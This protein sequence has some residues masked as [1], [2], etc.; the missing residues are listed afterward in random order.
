MTMSLYYYTARNAEGQAV[1]GSLEAAGGD[2]ALASLRTRALFVT[3]LS[4]ARSANGRLTAG[5]QMG[6]IRQGSLVAFF[7]SF[8]TLISAGVPM[9]RALAVGVEQA[10]DARFREALSAVRADVDAG[11]PLSLAMSKR[12]K[13]F[14]P[15]FVAM[16]HAG[17][18]GGVLDEVLERLAQFVERERVIRKRLAS[19]LTYPAIVAVSAAVLITFLL[20]SIVPMFASLYAQLHVELPPATAALLQV[21]R[22]ARAPHVWMLLG[23]IGAPA[24]L[25]AGHALRS[26]PGR[27]LIDKAKLRIPIVGPILRKTAV[28]RLTRMLGSLLKS[29]VNLVTAIDVASDVVAN[30]AYIAS[31]DDV[32]RSL[33]E[34]EAFAQPLRQSRLYE[35]LMIQM[36]AVGEETGTLDAMLLRIAEYYELDVETAVSALGSTLEPV[37]ILALGGVVGF[38]V[39]SIFIPLYTL[40]GNIK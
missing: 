3:S 19:A 2:A 35:P 18:A 14:A 23:A 36:I 32:R 37:L 34:G 25:T 27:T 31:L 1:R 30:R 8:A 40:I 33:R 11:T 13:E 38:I 10:G 15:I 16:I 7:R 21:G 17:E 28:A 12:P 6:A 22:S 24:V 9:R 26:G 4:S 29:G 20:S 5:F 39:F